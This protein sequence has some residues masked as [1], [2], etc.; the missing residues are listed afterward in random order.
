MNCPCLNVPTPEPTPF[1]G[2]PCL[3]TT[4]Q[5]VDWKN[6]LQCIAGVYPQ[7]GITQQQYNSF[8]GIVYS[9]VNH[10][11][12]PCYFKNDLDKILPYINL[13]IANELC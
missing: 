9:V 13:I 7:L 5:I 1:V 2:E 12:D 6:K 10:N 4:N 11:N 3:Y 8:L